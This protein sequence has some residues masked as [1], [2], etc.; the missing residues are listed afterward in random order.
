MLA[1]SLSSDST[2]SATGLFAAVVMKAGRV[3]RLALP[4]RSVHSPRRPL[5][6]HRCRGKAQPSRTLG[7]RAA[8]RRRRYSRHLHRRRAVRAPP[9]RQQFPDA[10]RRRRG[11]RVADVRRPVRDGSRTQATRT[12]ARGDPVR[13]HVAAVAENWTQL[14]GRR[15]I[16]EDRRSSGEENHRHGQH[17]P[18]GARLD[19]SFGLAFGTQSMIRLAAG[20]PRAA[21]P[22]RRPRADMRVG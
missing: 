5:P 20:T 3:S 12:R 22:I 17:Q 10:T 19:R 16:L 21:P 13:A 18:S 11:R 7:G 8:T 1:Q 6:R 2:S 9:R 4:S 15:P 14:L